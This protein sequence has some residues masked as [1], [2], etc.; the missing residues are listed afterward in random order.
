MINKKWL[1]AIN[2]IDF[3]FQPIICMESGVVLGYEALLRDFEKA[4]FKSIDDF[5]DLAYKEKVLF[6]VDVELRK[7][8]LK[9]I[10]PVYDKNNKIIIFFNLDNRIIEM[11]DYRTGLTSDIL[12]E[13]K[14]PKNFITF[15]VSE[16]YEFESFIKAKTVLNLYI[17]QGFNVALDDFGTGYS[18]LKML[19]NLNPKYIKI[20]RFFISDIVNDRRKRLYVTN[21]VN[22]AHQSNIQVIAEGIETLDE[23]LV[24]EEVGCDFVQGY[25]IQK[26]TTEI[27][28]LKKNYLKK[29]NKRKLLLNN[30]FN[31]DDIYYSSN[32]YND[33]ID[34]YIISSSTDCDGIITSVSS[35]FCQISGYS[36]QELIGKKHN[37]VKH[38]DMRS[39]IFKELWETIRNGNIWDGEIKNMRK[40]GESYW[41]EAK[42]SP[43]LNSNGE[44]IGF[45]SIRQDITDRKKLEQFVNVDYLT[46][47]WNKKYFDYIL[48][49]TINDL[50][51]ENR[52]ITLAL[53]DIDNFKAYNDNYGHKKGDEALQLLTS[54]ISKLLKKEE[55]LFRV[56][57]E[58]FAILIIDK[59]QDE[60]LKLF[61]QI[62]KH[63]NDL[64][65]E[66]KK[67]NNVSEYMTISCGI[68]CTESKKIKK[69]TNLF[70]NA[71]ILLYEAKNSGKNKIEISSKVYNSS[72]NVRVEN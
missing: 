30:N 21:I 7:K 45:T 9:K 36:K 26:P 1:K 69:N 15:E 61:N 20:D 39:S 4:G 18:G 49:K 54:C 47:V 67:N 5:F 34:K 23:F 70:V 33:L 37:I 40:N 6:K 22:I 60:I 58:E 44:I 35:A 10:K 14:L 41:V 16:K 32:I 12:A 68:I 57:G 56:G 42:I 66:H 48:E 11:D 65:I 53:I 13:L 72:L 3:A 28:K 51:N 17:E 46:K 52:F 27:A 59:N 19:Y 29:R 31:L 25:F 38:K 8:A 62:F 24:C 2:K 63:I 50:K 64:K 43:N 55:Y 71:D